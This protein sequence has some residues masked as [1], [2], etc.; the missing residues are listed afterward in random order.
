M[1]GECKIKLTPTPG[2]TQLKLNEYDYKC[3]TAPDCGNTFDSRSVLSF[4][5]S[6]LVELV[7]CHPTAFPVGHRCAVGGH[8]VQ[9]DSVAKCHTFF[10]WLLVLLLSVTSC[11]LCVRVPRSCATENTYRMF[12]PMLDPS[13]VL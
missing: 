8:R 12:D 9:G 4:V 13:L 3:V 1:L 7:V 10:L 11:G 6:R 5:G 2:E